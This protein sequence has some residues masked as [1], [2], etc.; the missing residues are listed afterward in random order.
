LKGEREIFPQN[1]NMSNISVK[2]S[3]FA[4]EISANFEEQLVGLKANAIEYIEVRGVNGKNISALNREEMNE[5]KKLLEKHKI[6]VS[7]IGSPVGKYNITDDFAPHFETFENCLL[8][9]EILD[10]KYMRMFSFFIPDG[11]YDEHRGE[12]L[13]RLEKLAESAAKKNVILCHENEREIYGESPERCLDLMKH[14]KGGIKFVFDP[15]NFVVGGFDTYPEAY[16]N[17]AE[18]IE[19][20]HIKDAGDEG[21]VP[22]GAGKGKIKEILS[23]LILN[24]KFS[25]FLSIEPHLSVFTGLKE[26]EGGEHSHVRNKFSSKEEAFAA[27]ADALKNILKDIGAN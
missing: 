1:K 12:V 26:L 15:A 18:Y 17:L 6:G 5:A 22:A 23:D 11:K 13:N 14:F 7:S 3:G 19:Y 10:T 25:N 2:L 27:A 24:R 4:D 16:N 9:A 20:M 21:I 8:A